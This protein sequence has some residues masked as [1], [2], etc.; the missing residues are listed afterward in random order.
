MGMRSAVFDEWL[1][2]QMDE[3]KDAI[4]IHIGCGMDS[5][6]NRVGTT[7]HDW[8]DVDFPDVIKERKLY[9]NESELYHMV[10]SDARQNLWI[11]ALPKDKNAVVVMEG[12]SMYFQRDELK[13]LLKE[14]TNHFNKIN[15]LMDCYTEFAAKAT[16][17]KN[18]INEVGVTVVYGIFQ[19]RCTGC[20]NI[21]RFSF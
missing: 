16:K 14:L 7:H 17:Y 5:R 19:K 18:P 11:E 12:V 13:K 1:R 6:I 9:Y 10:E 21:K 8:Y 15:I 2:T 3:N 20:L 4:I